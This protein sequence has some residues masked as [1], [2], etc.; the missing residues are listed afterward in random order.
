VNLAVAS[1]ELEDGTTSDC[2]AET[3]DGR[4]RQTLKDIAIAFLIEPKQDKQKSQATDT[5]KPGEGAGDLQKSQ[6]AGER[7]GC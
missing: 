6:R 5:A 7:N 2:E 1:Q 4:K 3:A